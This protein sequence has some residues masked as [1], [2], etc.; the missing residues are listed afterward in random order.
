[1]IIVG[2]VSGKF[3][4]GVLGIGGVA[5]FAMYTIIERIFISNIRGAWA[6][7]LHQ[8]IEKINA[9]G[10]DTDTFS[11]PAIRQRP[12]SVTIISW[13][14]IVSSVIGLVSTF[15]V[16]KPSDYEATLAINLLPAAFLM[17]YQLVCVFVGLLSGVFM[18]KG[19]AWARWLYIGWGA[20]GILVNFGN[21]GFTLF[22][23]PGLVVYTLL[24]AI[25]LRKNS[26]DFFSRLQ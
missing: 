7:E 24:T 5:G 6:P 19:A 4:P 17:A 3:L 20:L 14:L 11:L 8:V 9:C 25:L 22:A 26:S 16:M 21:F 2:V 23:I 15:V 1:M 13:F 10:S 18:L 12:I